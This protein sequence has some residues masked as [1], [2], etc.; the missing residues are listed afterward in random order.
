[1][2]AICPFINEECMT[3]RC[4][5]WVVE[6]CQCTFRAMLFRLGRIERDIVTFK[7]EME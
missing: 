4:Q 2:T 7:P 5:L 6:R 3:T 1:M